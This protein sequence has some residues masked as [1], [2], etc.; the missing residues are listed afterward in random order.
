MR[1]ATRDT[2]EE[3]YIWRCDQ[4]QEWSTQSFTTRSTHYFTRFNNLTL[5]F[6]PS[7]LDFRRPDALAGRCQVNLLS[8]LFNGS[9]F[10]RQ[11]PAIESQ[12]HHVYKNRPDSRASKTFQDINAVR[13]SLLFVRYYILCCLVN[14]LRSNWSIGFNPAK[15]TRKTLLQ[16]RIPIPG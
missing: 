6:L 8:A 14:M 12:G 2:S 10:S 3:V 5:V 1:H 9:R 13:N 11:L 15:E 16:V 7:F 4:Q